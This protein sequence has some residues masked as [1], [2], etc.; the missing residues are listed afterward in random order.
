MK[1]ILALITIFVMVLSLSVVSVSAA[2]GYATAD[3]NLTLKAV[4]TGVRNGRAQIAFTLSTT[5]TD[6]NAGAGLYDADWQEYL[7]GTIKGFVSA[8]VSYKALAPVFAEA[9]GSLALVDTT[10]PYEIKA[11]TSVSANLT[12]NL[13]ADYASK[14][15]DEL[16][17]MDI[18]EVTLVTADI[19]E[20]TCANYTANLSK[21]TSYATDGNGDF[22]VAVVVPEASEEEPEEFVVAE[23]ADTGYK[24]A[25]F[26]KNV[27]KETFAAETY[28]INF[29]GVNFVAGVDKDNASIECKAGETFVVAFDDPEGDLKAGTYTYYAYYNNGA[30]KSNEGT[31]VID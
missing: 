4:V 16:N 5:A 10:Y 12:L 21:W 7:D 28:G 26:A 9:T 13:T 3:D 24:V 29:G 20:Y 19:K 11:D 1:K 22:G 17:A 2:G 30:N 15:A 14:T 31:V 8:G 18:I 27:T 25:F 6:F 23:K